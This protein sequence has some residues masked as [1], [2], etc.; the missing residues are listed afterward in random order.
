VAVDFEVIIVGSGPAGSSTALHLAKLAPRLAARTLLL[1]KA[2]HPRVKLCAGGVTGK[3][4]RILAGLGLP[5]RVDALAMD[6]VEIRYL[7]HRRHTRCAGLGVT[8]QRPAF[9]GWLAHAAAGRGVSLHE[10]EVFTALRVGEDTITLTT[11][12]GSYTAR[13]VVAADGA[14]SRVR[15]AAGFPA[16]PHRARLL[17]VDTP[18]GP[19][20]ADLREDTLY[21]DFTPVAH[22]IHGYVWD[23]PT[24]IRGQSYINRGIYDRGDPGSR[25]GSLKGP[26]REALA[27]RGVDLDAHRLRGHLEREIDLATPVARPRVLLAGEAAGIDPTLGEG[28]SQALAYGALAARQLIDAHR[29]GDWTF[30]GYGRRLRRSR[31]G[32]ELRGTVDLARRLYGPEGEDYLALFLRSPRINRL[33]ARFLAGR[34]HPAAL[35]MAILPSLAVHALWGRKRLV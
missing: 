4:L 16:P 28:I 31:L 13:A 14:G 35:S 11:D 32:M 7:H 8:I 23:F 26:F 29:R 30:R 34:L 12:R 25:K 2:V 19:R 6:G 10:G 33:G 15:R 20:D 17:M 24:C 27:E 21:L 1:E 3:G 22:G 9:D 5:L 18:R